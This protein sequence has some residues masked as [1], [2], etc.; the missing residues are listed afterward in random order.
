MLSEIKNVSGTST[1]L[2]ALGDGSFGAAVGA[3]SSD[4]SLYMAGRIAVGI[5]FVPGTDGDWTAPEIDAVFASTTVALDSFVD[6]EPNANISFVHVKEV[7]ANSVPN[8]LP[9][10]NITYINDLRNI[11][12]TH[13]SFMI[14]AYHGSG[15]GFTLGAEF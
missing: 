15:F 9:A 10:N 13:W 12:N 1:I 5:F 4:T 14:R 2:A 11:H 6:E 8:P 3:G 7:D